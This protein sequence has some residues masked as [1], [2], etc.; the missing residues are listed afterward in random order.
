MTELIKADVVRKRQIIGRNVKNAEFGAQFYYSPMHAWT[1]TDSCVRRMMP[2]F[3]PRLQRKKTNGDKA[4]CQ[5]VLD[6]CDHFN[7]HVRARHRCTCWQDN[8]AEKLLL[9][10]AKWSSSLFQQV[11][12]F[13]FRQHL[14]FEHS[15]KQIREKVFINEN[16]GWEQLWGQLHPL[17]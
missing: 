12:L 1:L 11:I 13:R 6:H 10:G 4:T 5:K 9:N 8:G 14:Q 15:R 3:F 16:E 7:F 17:R 2:C